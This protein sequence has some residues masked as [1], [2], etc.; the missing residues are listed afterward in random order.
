M[1]PTPSSVLVVTPH[2][3]DFEFGCAGIVAKWIKEGAKAVLVVATN[4]DKGTD[5]PEMTSEKLAAIR[6]EEQ[7]EAGRVLGLS[8]VVF[9][10]Y[11]DGGLEDTTEFRG[12]L[13]RNLRIHKPDAV[14]TTYPLR[15]SFYLH[16][17]HRM[18]GQVTLDASFPY[19]R[20][21]LHFPEHAAEGLEPHKV[22]HILVLGKRGP[23]HPLRHLRNYRPEDCGPEVPQE[24]GGRYGRLERGRQFAESRRKPGQ[25]QRHSLRRGVQ[26]DEPSGLGRRL[27][28]LHSHILPG[29]DD[30]AKTIEESMKML[31]AA[32]GDGI[33]GMAATPHGKD[34]REAGAIGLVAEHVETLNRLADEETLDIKIYVGMENHLTLDLPELIA[35]GAGFPINSGPYILVELPFDSLPD[36]TDEVLTRLQEQGLTPL[37]AHPERQADIMRDPSIMGDLVGR[38]ML[39]QVT[40]TCILGRFGPEARDTAELLLKNGWVH[41]ISTD[42]HRPTGPRAPMMAESVVEAGKIVG[43]ETARAMAVDVPRSILMGRPIEV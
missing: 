37:I 40:S 7:L 12:K 19:A 26:S 8:E 23:R 29:L 17:D 39:G 24:P 18:A 1:I 36:Y 43:L 31:R 2:P 16:R 11:P 13:V 33:R 28:D 10:D 32:A 5:D 30:G 9:L 27:F 38:G 25:G 35:S 21:R 14:F 3:D 20:D 41:V 34:V 15:R 6:R 4:G 22:K 42:C